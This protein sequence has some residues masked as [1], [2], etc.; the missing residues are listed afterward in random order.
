MS[1][2]AV[3]NQKGGIGKTTTAVALAA[4]VIDSGRRALL[5]DMDAQASA[6]AAVGFDFIE[7]EDDPNLYTAMSRAR[8]RNPLNLLGTLYDSNLGPVSLIPADIKLA[9]LE[10]QLIQVVRREYI[11]SD[12]LSGLRTQFDAIILDCPPSLG[13]LTLNALT[14]ADDVLI[15]CVPDYL[16]ARG[17]AGLHDTVELVQRQLNP[18]LTVAGVLLTRVRPQTIEYRNRRGDIKDFCGS[19]G[20]PVL[21]MEIPDTI[22]AAMTAGEGIPL[23]RHPAGNGARDAYLALATDLFPLEVSHAR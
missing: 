13:W 20:V 5:I 11:L 4:A 2:L 9:E 23:T 14:A 16:S 17:L 12:L 6:S 1:V 7:H 19:W 3:V 10:T 22:R 8:S 18:A 21:P 15:P